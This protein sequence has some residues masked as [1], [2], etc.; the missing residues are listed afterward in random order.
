M[1]SVK[2]M[3]RVITEVINISQNNLHH[4]IITMQ[5]VLL[6]ALISFYEFALLKKKFTYTLLKTL[7]VQYIMA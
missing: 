7:S 4:K 2:N 5:L 6:N 3:C 1:M